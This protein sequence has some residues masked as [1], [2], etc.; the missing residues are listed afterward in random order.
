MNPGGRRLI[1]VVLDRRYRIDAPI[2]RG[3]MSTV[4]R[5]MDLRL[6]RPVA[7]KVMDPQFAA[8]PQFLARFEFEARAVARLAHPGLV[9]VH[10]QGSDGEHAFLVMELVEGGT[11]REL[12]RERGPMPP[13]AA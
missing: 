5:G 4:Y 11:L 7:I 6:D 10:D 9:A 8:D 13:H 12:L 1:G 2:A 3:G